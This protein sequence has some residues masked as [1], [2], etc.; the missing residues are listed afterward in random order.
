MIR[1]MVPL[2]CII[3]RSRQNVHRLGLPNDRNGVFLVLKLIKPFYFSIPVYIRVN[4]AG[5]IW[6]I[7]E[8]VALAGLVDFGQSY[9]SRFQPFKTKPPDPAKR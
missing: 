9:C 5:L 2:S 6:S 4:Q 7:S 1:Q 3:L 8:S